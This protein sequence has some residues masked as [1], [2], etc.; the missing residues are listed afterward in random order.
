MKI[1]V[2]SDYVEVLTEIDIQTPI[3]D[4]LQTIRKARNFLFL[5]CRFTNQLERSFARQIMKRS[6]DKH[7]AIIEGEL[8]RNEEKF[9][10]EQNIT[11]IDASLA[12]FTKALAQNDVEAVAA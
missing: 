4:S 7:W 6:S 10:R 5:G 11:R 2:H 1:L 3:P 8:T 12:D 9:L